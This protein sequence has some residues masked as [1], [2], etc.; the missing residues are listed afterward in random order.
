MRKG[1]LCPTLILVFMVTIPVVSADY[2]G[3]VEYSIGDSI[4][5]I[6]LTSDDSWTNDDSSDILCWIDENYVNND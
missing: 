5:D 1:I 4:F 3:E 2:S 6:E